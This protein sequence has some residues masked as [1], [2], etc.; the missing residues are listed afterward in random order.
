MVGSSKAGVEEWSDLQRQVLRNG[1]IFFSVAVVVLCV[2]AP[3]CCRGSLCFSS[4]LLPLFSV[5]QLHVVTGGLR[6]SD[7]KDSSKVGVD[8]WSDLQR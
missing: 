2:S 1:R 3:R 7:P 4:T 8:E 5:F 6:P